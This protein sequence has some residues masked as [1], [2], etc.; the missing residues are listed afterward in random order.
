MEEKLDG[1]NKEKK[2]TPG[3]HSNHLLRTRKVKPLSVSQVLEAGH[4]ELRGIVWGGFHEAVTVEG[5]RH[6]CVFPSAACDGQRYFAGS[7]EVS[8]CS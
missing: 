3:N 2:K 5:T 7:F 4:Q 1:F 8:P 6:C